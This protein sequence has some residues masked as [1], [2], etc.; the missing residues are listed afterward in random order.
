LKAEIAC[1]YGM[2]RFRQGR[3]KD[4]VRLLNKGLNAAESAGAADVMAT[5]LSQI[6]TVE[7]AV[8]L[9]GD[10]GHAR[11]ALDIVQ[12][13]GDKPWLEARVLNNLGYRAYFAGRWP[14]AVMYY[15]DSMAACEKAGDQWTAS[16]ESANLAEVRSDQGHLTEAEPM[17]EEALR[18]SRAAGTQGFTG[19]NARLLGRVAA[20]LGDHARAESLFKMARKAGASE[21]DTLE[22]LYTDAFTAECRY[23]G[24]SARD[25]VEV[26][27]NALAEAT[28]IPGSEMVI[29]LLQRVRALGL[30]D[31][32]EKN[33]AGMALRASIEYARMMKLPY[34]L[35]MSTQ[36]LI[37][38]APEDVSNDERDECEELF[39]LLGVVEEARRLQARVA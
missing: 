5:A 36:A 30:A 6:D 26:A 32:G 7:V 39:E 15:S 21:G 35:A 3:A 12:D 9:G 24:G 29:P 17:L 38:T 27:E 2:V 31:L 25:A 16:L 34:E 18:I 23:L 10:G 11:R 37:D 8:G 19:L 20:R 13:L 28:K 4:A 1:L 22:A 14:E 33:T